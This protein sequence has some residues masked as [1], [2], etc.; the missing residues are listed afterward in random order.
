MVVRFHLERHRQ[1]IADID[2]AS[3]LTRPKQHVPA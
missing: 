2:R 3:V 1:A